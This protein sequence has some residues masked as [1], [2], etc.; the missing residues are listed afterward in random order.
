MQENEA[1]SGLEIARLGARIPPYVTPT[2]TSFQHLLSSKSLLFLCSRYY[3]NL[4]AHCLFHSTF[5]AAQGMS[6]AYLE[7]SWPLLWGSDF[8]PFNTDAYHD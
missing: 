1:Q 5:E 4:K 7:A 3:A 8:Q 2:L 6:L